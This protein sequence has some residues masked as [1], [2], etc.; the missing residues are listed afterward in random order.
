MAEMLSLGVQVPSREKF[1]RAWLKM[2]LL[3]VLKRLLMASPFAHSCS[4]GRSAG[5]GPPV[6][7]VNADKDVSDPGNEDSDV[8]GPFEAISFRVPALSRWHLIVS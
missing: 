1:P 7:H 5:R 4:R 6:L 2:S 3:P 8:V